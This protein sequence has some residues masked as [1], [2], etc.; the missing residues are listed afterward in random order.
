[1][2]KP[3]IHRAAVSFGL[4]NLYLLA[5]TGPL[6]SSAHDL[7]YHLTGSASVIFIPVIINLLALWVVFIGL[8]ALAE[9][10]ERLMVAIWSATLLALPWILVKTFMGFFGSSVP[11]WVSALIALA[12]LA[13]F[14]AIVL[15]G[16]MRRAF[17]K[18]Q[19][20]AATVLGF[21]ALCGVLIL[22]QLVWFGWQARDLNPAPRLHQ[23]NTAT[24]VVKPHI[25]WIVLDE[26]SYQQVYEQRF[27]G[28]Q[29]PA[30]DQLEAEST[31]FTQVT[32]AGEYTRQVLPS[33]L[34]GTP[35]NGISVSGAG[36]LSALHNAATHQWVR[37]S[38]Q[39]TVFR[40]AL[41]AGYSTGLVGWYNP[42][43]RILPSVLD[44]C[45]WMY[46]EDT[47][48]RLS[49][50]GNAAL[51][52]VLP[53]R[54]LWKRVRH[55]FGIG[56]AVLSA[57]QIDIR[58]HSGDYRDLLAAGDDLL[59]DPSANFILLHMPVPHPFGFYDRKSG[60]IALH[61]TSYIDNLAL[62]DRYLGHVRTLLAERGEWDSSTV[63]VMGDHSWRTKLIWANSDGWLA[64]DQAASHGGKFD[65]RPA[66]LVKLPNEHG[67]AR[68]DTPFAAVRTRAM[69]DA[70]LQGRVQSPAELQ[71]WVAN[72]R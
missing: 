21:F 10:S 22:C 28:L 52:T 67:S 31:M 72:Q 46:H 25:I 69:F 24:A 57:E 36:M 48:A 42:Y 39:D 29:L 38:P 35:V 49:P 26:L 17:E 44:H 9:R 51:N 64:E 34:T 30:F 23:E 4:A 1:M 53:L 60:Q 15:S 59:N 54:L 58:M 62:A 47:P 6:I 43:C 65:S 37:F 41:N 14:L 32:P 56:P 33:L 27:P 71:S 2:V 55:F 5:L 18:V 45:Y 61:H 8:F 20:L 3:F 50:Q 40:D 68:I 16:R 70:M 66:Y 19:P 63:V 7:V 11:R 12:S 13:T